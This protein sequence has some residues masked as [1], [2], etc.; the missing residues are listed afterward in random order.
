MLANKSVVSFTVYGRG[1]ISLFYDVSRAERELTDDVIE[2]IN[3]IQLYIPVKG[4]V[5]LEDDPALFQERIQ[6]LPGLAQRFGHGRVDLGPGSLT[7]NQLVGL[8]Q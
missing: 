4:D 6:I 5:V 1:V 2:A 7:G 3:L 8:F